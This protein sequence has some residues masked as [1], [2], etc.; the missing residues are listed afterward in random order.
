MRGSFSFTLR[1]LATKRPTLM[2]AVPYMGWL[3]AGVLALGIETGASPSSVQKGGRVSDLERLVAIED[4]KHLMASYARFVDNRMYDQFRDTLAPDCIFEDFPPGGGPTRGNQAIADTVRSL[5]GDR[6]GAHNIIMPEIEI[7]SPA[8]AK[9]F[10]RLNQYQTYDLTYEKIPGLGWRIKTW[11]L[12]REPGPP[13]P[14]SGDQD[15]P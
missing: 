13:T 14:S 11:R 15:R 9:A 5:V 12:L 8:T 6:R 1:Q 2:Q 4:I 3:L 7:T 10:W